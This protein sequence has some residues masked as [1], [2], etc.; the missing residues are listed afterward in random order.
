M[1]LSPKSRQDW[2]D[3]G[4]RLKIDSKPLL[5]LSPFIAQAQKF[6][7]TSP[8]FDGLVSLEYRI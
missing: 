4:C 3:P 1:N 6:H 8:V 5:C 7:S 2:E